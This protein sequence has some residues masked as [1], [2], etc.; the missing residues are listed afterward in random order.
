MSG[1][2]AVLVLL[3]WAGVAALVVWVSRRKARKKREA[4]DSYAELR[5]FAEER[6]WTYEE[7]VQGLTGGGPYRR[8]D[9]GV[10]GYNVVSG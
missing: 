7:T 6:G 9:Q 2:E 4:R 1:M 10:Q 5:T 8:W 3:W